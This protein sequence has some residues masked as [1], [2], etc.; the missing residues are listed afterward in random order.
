MITLTI[1]IT[2]GGAF[3]GVMRGY[4]LNRTDLEPYYEGKNTTITADVAVS[5]IVCGLE[6]VTPNSAHAATLT[7]RSATTSETYDTHPLSE[8]F[9]ITSGSDAYDYTLCPALTHA[10]CTDAACASPLTS[11]SFYVDL[12][13][14]LLTLRVDQPQA[15]VTYHLGIRPANQDWVTQQISIEVCGWQTYQVADSSH[16]IFTVLDTMD[17]SSPCTATLDLD[18]TGVFAPTV[19]SSYCSIIDYRV[20][21]F[22]SC[23]ETDTTRFSYPS[24]TSISVDLCSGLPST[25]LYLGVHAMGG[26]FTT[27]PM[28]IEI[29]GHESWS[30]TT[31]ALQHEI[32]N[33]FLRNVGE[34]V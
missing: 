26:Q 27:A 18:V 19:A 28:S 17:H 22:S 23:N 31:T 8:F 9:A 21:P 3:S 1:D 25:T 13:N 10:L 16:A 12:Q 32:F 29:C 6:I 24:A 4:Q 15:P 7:Q 33:H 20:C 5:V 34:D 2:N 30:L 11:S 14:S